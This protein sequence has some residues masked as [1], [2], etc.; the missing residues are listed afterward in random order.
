MGATLGISEDLVWMPSRGTYDSVLKGIAQ[1]SSSKNKAISE[2]FERSVSDYTGGMLFLDDWTDP[3]DFQVVLDA[4]LAHRDF[5]LKKAPVPQPEWFLYYID[6][7]DELV[8]ILE[9]NID[10]MKSA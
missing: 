2:L 3:E 9:K 8:H 1:F 7:I 5:E 4:L 6:S 10:T